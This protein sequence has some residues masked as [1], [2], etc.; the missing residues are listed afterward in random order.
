MKMLSI[1]SLIMKCFDNNGNELN[2]A[3]ATTLENY[4]SNKIEYTNMRQI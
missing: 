3:Y 2:G 4:L 1:N